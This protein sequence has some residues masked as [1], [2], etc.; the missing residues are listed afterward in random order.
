MKHIPG[1]GKILHLGA[2]FTENALIGDVSIQ[3]KIDG[4]QFRFGINEDGEVVCASKAVPIDLDNPAEL[5]RE[6]V[7]Y[8]REAMKKV[9]F[10][11]IYFYG[12]YLKKSKHNTLAYDQI[13]RNHIVI[14]DGMRDGKWMTRDV[15][16]HYATLL[17]IDL[18]PELYKGPAD[19]QKILDL[20]HTQSYLGGQILEGL[21]IKNY[22]QTIEMHGRVQNLFTKYVREEFKELH[23]KN[24]EYISRGDKVE[25]LFMDYHA[26]TRWNKAVQHLRD[27][28]ELEVSPRDIGKLM[29]EVPEDILM[30]CE[31]EI[32]DRLFALCKKDF[33]KIVTRGL[34]E[35]YKKSL[36][37]NLKEGK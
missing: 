4:S 19:T 24:P 36:L 16:E 30:E 3:E 10:K 31:Q 27:R 8:V 35:W 18:I 29:V 32:K 6:G 9:V 14:F 37:G 13:P 33:T 28:A 26:E 15:L 1:Y 11:D 5:F 12:E 20:L 17:D 21:V 23:K 2:Q 22:T 34:P 25:A 7:D